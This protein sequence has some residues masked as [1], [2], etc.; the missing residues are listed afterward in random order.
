MALG[1]RL[2]LRQSQS[3][4]MTPQLQQAIKLLALS[5]LEIE[6]W[7]GE[8]LD[9][10]PLLEMASG[11][12]TAPDISTLAGPPEEARRTS[13]ESSPIDQLIG[14]GRAAEDRPVEALDNP[15]EMDRD[16][17]AGEA[18]PGDSGDWG[19]EMRSAA[20][21]DAGFPDEREQAGETLAEHLLAQIGT[22]TNR[23]SNKVVTQ[24]AAALKNRSPANDR[25]IVDSDE[26]DISASQAP[27][28]LDRR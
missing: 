26:P 23:P 14:E 9:S 16:T 3:L 2:D 27:I 21:E 5:N 15:G 22:A 17:G 25:Q 10:N 6:T 12:D 11:D 18:G 8:A 13:L 7:I 4:V 24:T 28:M 20:G 19:R 1:P